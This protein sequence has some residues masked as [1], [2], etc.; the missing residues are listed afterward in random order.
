MEQMRHGIDSSRFELI[1]EIYGDRALEQLASDKEEQRIK[2]VLLDAV[3]LNDPLTGLPQ[4]FEPDEIARRIKEIRPGLP[5]F[6]VSWFRRGGLSVPVDGV[7]PKATLFKT[8]LTFRDLEEALDDAISIIEVS[9]FYPDDGGGASWKRRWGP[10]YIELRNSPGFASEQAAVGKR[11]REDYDI[12]EDSEIG[13]TYRKYRG[14]DTLKNVLIARR[15]IFATVFA[16]YKND[17]G[18]IWREVSEFLKFDFPYDE[19]ANEGEIHEGLRNLMNGCGI[20]WGNII[21]RST[22]LDEEE[23]WLKLENFMNL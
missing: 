6:A 18:V 20:K 14:A 13:E 10:E 17:K 19:G 16:C 8:P 23:A 22:L 7:Y 12:L 2:A 15:V 3:E 9:S 11:A 1:G 21:N 5:V 4:A